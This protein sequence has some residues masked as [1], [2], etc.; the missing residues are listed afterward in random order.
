MD[1]QQEQDIPMPEMPQPSTIIQPN[2]PVAQGPT[3]PIETPVAAPIQPTVQPQPEAPTMPAA[4]PISQL[5]QQPVPGPAPQ[6]DYPTNSMVGMTGSSLPPEKNRKKFILPGA[7]IV[8]LLVCSGVYAF[9]FYIPNKPENV[10]KTGL[11]RSGD[12]LDELV[13]KATTQEELDKFKKSEVNVQVTANIEDSY[14]LDGT[15]SAKFDSTQLDAGVDVKVT[16]EGQE[17]IDLALDVLSK[18]AEDKKFPDTYFKASGYSSLGL[19]ELLPGIEKYEDKWIA[20]TSDYLEEQASAA[21][22]TAGESESGLTDVTAQDISE[23]AKTVVS[24]SN[25]YI[26]TADADKALLV[27]KEFIGKEDINGAKAFHYV[28]SI[29]EDNAVKFCNAMTDNLLATE[30]MKK[31]LDNPTEEDIKG[32]KEDIGCDGFKDSLDDNFT[33]DIWIDAKYKLIT[34]ARFYDENKEEYLEVGQSYNGGDEVPF[35]LDFSKLPDAPTEARATFTIN[36]KDATT[37][38]EVKVKE[39]GDSPYDVYASVEVKPFTGELNVTKPAGAIDA[40]KVLKDIQS[41]YGAPVLGI[42]TDQ[43]ITS[44]VQYLPAELLQLQLQ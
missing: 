2:Q 29:N 6:V 43:P 10:W 14:K 38:G 44:L 22:L 9:A 32:Y 5:P 26:F 35:Y 21:G 28:V 34:V 41:G 13:S 12:V 30:S 3:A 11:N 39:D 4:E 27:N 8:F 17:A 23:I 1:P 20:I 24:T 31:L 15:M 37:K 42:N 18:Q 36:L 16:D 40:E 25:E 7:L 33:F 19:N